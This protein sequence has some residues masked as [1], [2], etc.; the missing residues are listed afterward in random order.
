MLKSHIVMDLSQY[1][2]DGLHVMDEIMNDK[3]N[4]L[5][6]RR[7]MVDYVMDDGSVITLDD[8]LSK[9]INLYKNM[10]SV[11]KLPNKFKMKPHH[12]SYYKYKTYVLGYFLMKLNNVYDPAMFTMDDVFYLDKT[13]I[14]IFMDNLKNRDSDIY[15]TGLYDSYITI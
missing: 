3:N 1:N 11:E 2:N 14:L 5:S 7:I 13:A 12:Y 4:I 9:H 10:A 6:T 8:F 15:G